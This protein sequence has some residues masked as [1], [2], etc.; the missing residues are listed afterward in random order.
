MNGRF[1]KL[2]FLMPSVSIVDFTKQQEEQ[3][4]RNE[5]TQMNDAD[6]QSL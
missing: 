6:T 4:K 3:H 1:L 2:Q 5:S